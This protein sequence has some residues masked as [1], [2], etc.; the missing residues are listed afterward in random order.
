MIQT[1]ALLDLAFAPTVATDRYPTAI[2]LVLGVLSRRFT[3]AHRVLG[4]NATRLLL[5]QP[6]TCHCLQ[7]CLQFSTPSFPFGNFFL[8]SVEKVAKR[9]LDYL[10]IRGGFLCHILNNLPAIGLDHE[11]PHVVLGGRVAG[12]EDGVDQ[13]LQFGTKFVRHEL[14]LLQLIKNAGH[15]DPIGRLKIIIFRQSDHEIVLLRLRLFSE[16]IIILFR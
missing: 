4:W 3:N 7:L 6:Q 16:T 8:H 14:H 2:T 9:L 10:E 1:I 5:F 12:L 15:W 13:V 11:A